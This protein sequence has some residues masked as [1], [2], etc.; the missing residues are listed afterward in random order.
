M[1][2]IKI[3]KRNVKMIAHRGVSGLETENTCAAFISACNRSYWG[4]E[5]D[6]YRTSDG[7]F[8]VFHDKTTMRLAGSDYNIE[9]TGYEKLKNLVLKDID[10]SFIRTD[11]R[12]A[13]LEE[14][15]SI[16]KKYD[17]KCILEFKSSFGKKEMEEIFGIIESFHFS[18]NVIPIGSLNDMILLRELRPGQPAQY[19]CR[20]LEKKLHETA[21]ILAKN[22]LELD[23]DFRYLTSKM[24]NCL[25]AKGV[26]I[27]VWTCND[28]AE[29]EKLIDMGVD[30]IT[31]DILE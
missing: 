2:T 17:K 3:K 8:V 30:Y 19:L 27:N 24:L 25:H 6:L 10:G 7:R 11:L 21:D 1:D 14:Y 12:I 9:Q 15:I 20:D 23:I 29:A 18:E 22:R 13:L 5:T 28:P 31:S 4:I 16:C 26:Q